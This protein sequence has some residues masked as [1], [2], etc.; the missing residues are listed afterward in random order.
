MFSRGSPD[1]AIMSAYFPGWREPGRFDLPRRSAALLVADWIACIGV[2]PYFTMNANWRALMPC[3]QT[4]AA[5]PKDIFTP[6][7]TGFLKF[8]RWILPRA[9]SWSRKSA[10]GFFF[11]AA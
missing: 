7:R 11:L 9:R 2:M 8:L 1:T 6:A 5:G 4:P 10:G 3:G